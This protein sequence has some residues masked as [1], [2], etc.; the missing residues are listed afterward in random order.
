MSLRTTASLTR[1][2]DAACRIVRQRRNSG[3]GQAGKPFVCRTCCTLREQR[4]SYLCRAFARAK[5]DS[6]GEFS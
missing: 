1:N 5:L 4:L 2:M 6:Q 3:A